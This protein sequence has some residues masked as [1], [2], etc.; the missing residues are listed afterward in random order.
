MLAVFCKPAYVTDS[1]GLSA[2]L[3]ALLLANIQQRAFLC[4]CI[5][6]GVQVCFSRYT[7]RRKILSTSVFIYQEIC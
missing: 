2:A 3:Y 1:A 5:L 7:C 6:A 4:C